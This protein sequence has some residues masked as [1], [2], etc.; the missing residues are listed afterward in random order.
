[1]AT[2]YVPA[3]KVVGE[4]KDRFH[5]FFITNYQAYTVESSDIL[6]FWRRDRQSA[7]SEDRN[8]KYVVS[9]EGRERVDSFVDFLSETCEMIGEQ[10]IYLTMG[11]KSW[12]VRPRAA[13]DQDATVP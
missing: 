2:F 3:A 13:V 11:H 6:G 8:L 12:L 7:L 9:F 10:C 1:M 4:V 5:D